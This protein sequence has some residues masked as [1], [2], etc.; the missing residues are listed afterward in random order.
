M[1]VR[2]LALLLAP[3]SFCAGADFSGDWI[4][5]VSGGFGD[6]QYFRATLKGDGAKLAGSW[7]DASLDGATTGDTLEFS[8]HPTHGRGSG[9]FKARLL[10]AEISGQG[11]MDGLRGRQTVSLKMTRSPQP[12]AGGPKTV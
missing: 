5:Q 11:E 7:N 12:R 8:V 9:T 2:T 6:P 3:V 10:G 1:T 4:A